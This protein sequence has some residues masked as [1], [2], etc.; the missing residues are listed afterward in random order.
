MQIPL[1]IAYC[2]ESSVYRRWQPEQGGVSPLHKEIRVSH[3]LSKVLGLPTNQVRVWVVPHLL[4]LLTT[5]QDLVGHQ[6][7]DID[8]IVMHEASLLPVAGNQALR[9]QQ[10][11]ITPFIPMLPKMVRCQTESLIP[12]KMR[13]M[14]LKKKTMPKKTKTGSRPQVMGRRYLMVKTG[15]STLIPRTPSP[16]LVSS[17]ANMRTLTPSQTL[18]R[19]SS[20]HSKGGA[21]TAL[22]RTSPRKTPAYHHLLR[23]SHQ[24]TRHSVM[25]PDKKRGCWTHALMLGGMTK[26]PMVLWVTRDTMICDLSE[27]GKMQPNHPDPIGPP[28]EY[29]AECKVFDSIWS[30]LYDLCHFYTLGMTGNLPELPTPQESV[31]CSQV[32]DLLMSAQSTG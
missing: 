3:T 23:K 29:M 19:K 26:L 24:P 13:E 21:R 14:V 8:L 17:S 20:Q 27:H 6:A 12:P 32:R 4:L 10:L 18:G 31:I 2:L 16:V 22:R 5:L 28:L 7:L 30:D 9:A 11:S 1:T 15:R 25:G